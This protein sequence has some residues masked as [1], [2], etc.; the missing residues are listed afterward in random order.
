MQWGK[1]ETVTARAINVQGKE[2]LSKT[3][4]VNKGAN[5]IKIDE[6]SN[7][8]S[9]NYFIQLISPTERFTQKVTK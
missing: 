8:P 2:V 1:S 7:L 6:L 3:M 9:G 4:L 5:Y